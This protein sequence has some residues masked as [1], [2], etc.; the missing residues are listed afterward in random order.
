MSNFI[1]AVAFAVVA[2]IVV[3]VAAAEQDATQDATSDTQASRHKEAIGAAAG[4]LTMPREA[5]LKKDYGAMRDHM[6]QAQELVD[7][8]DDI[9]K[10]R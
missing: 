2:A 4:A 8:V 1:L 3:P 7:A 9:V 5:I 10:D 6:E